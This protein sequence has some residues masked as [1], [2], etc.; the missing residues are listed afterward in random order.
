M[1]FFTGFGGVLITAILISGVLAIFI[2]ALIIVM[3]I[4]IIMLY[5]EKKKNKNKDNTDLQSGGKI[6][7]SLLAM[8]LFMYHHVIFSIAFF[9]S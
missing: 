2:F 5:K 6:I 8:R 3:T 1:L 9:R 7:Q 4:T